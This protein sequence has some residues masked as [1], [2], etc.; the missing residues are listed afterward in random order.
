[1][2]TI[3]CHT[4]VAS[5]RKYVGLTKQSW[6]Q[7]WKNHCFAAKTSKNGRW[8][9]PNAIRM[10]GPEAFNHEVLE[11]CSTL[12]EA[13]AAEIKWIVHHDTRNPEKGFNLAPGGNHAPHPVSNSYW[14][15]P[16][17]KEAHIAKTTAAL[18]TPQSKAKRR[19]A[20][21]ALWSDSEYVAK[22]SEALRE[23]RLDPETRQRASA[24]Q[25]GKT[26]PDEQRAK[27][28]ASSRS[29][30]PDVRA[31]ISEAVNDPAVRSKIKTSIQEYWDNP[32]SHIKASE[33]SKKIHSRLDVKEKLSNHIL[34]A[35][36]KSK[37]AQSIKS[38]YMTDTHKICKKHG[39][40]PLE[41]CIKMQGNTGIRYRCGPCRKEKPKRNK[42]RVIP[43]KVV[44]SRDKILQEC[45]DFFRRYGEWPTKSN[46]LERKWKR[47]DDALRRG[48]RGLPSGSSLYL[49]LKESNKICLD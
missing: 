37:I 6:Q 44:F 47:Y 41:R 27:I 45:D 32:E 28:S 49:L 9:F 17:F 18:N 39:L 42:S 22:Q 43:Q 38:K 8:H 30:D 20:S 25:R 14:L 31:K 2:W 7:R 15:Q 26:L 35:E 12:E 11:V 5:D 36:S 24:A 10:Y 19:A 33:V 46:K 34:S 29:A 40:V 3:Y 4:H 48:Y 16:G 23:A 13:N 21:R 1:M